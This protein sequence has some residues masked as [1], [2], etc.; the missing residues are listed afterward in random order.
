MKTYF[1]KMK[2]YMAV[3]ILTFAGAGCNSWLDL[4]PEND[5]TSDMYWNT[6]ED[7]EAVVMSGYTSMRGCLE[8]LIQWG[9]LRG[10]ALTLGTKS[11]TSEQEIYFL[12]ILTTNSVCAWK[13][14]YTVIGNANAVIKYGPTVLEK[15][16]T[17]APELM[18]SYIGEAKFMRALA[19]F[20][21]LRTFG[22]V[23]LVLEPYV[24]DA[25]E[26]KQAKVSE[27]EVLNQIIADL[28]E[29]TVKCKPGYGDIAKNKGRATSWAAYALLADVYL[30]N[31]NYQ[32]ALDACEKVI[33][34]GQFSLVKK[35][36]WYTLFNPGNTD[37]GIFELQWKSP[38]SKVTNNLYEWF[39]NSP[40]YVLSYRSTQLFSEMTENDNRGLGASYLEDKRVWKYAG[41]AISLDGSATRAAE[42]RNAN[43]IFYRYADVLLMKAEAL[44]MKER[45]VEEADRS[46]AKTWDLVKVIRERAGFSQHPGIPQNER[47]ALEMVLD[48]RHREFIGEGKRWFDIL[49]MAKRDDYQYKDYLLEVILQNVSAQDRP[50]YEAKLVD[51]RG[52]YL[53]IHKDEI[54]ANGGVLVQ[55]PYYQDLE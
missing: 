25:K 41:K 45:G 28:K 39:Y 29:A 35:A 9:E 12:Q 2:I 51:V 20:Y 7:V 43:W 55:N 37:E 49:R 52:Y 34:S 5:Q 3:L 10:D 42:D 26:F 33:G 1:K 53:P 19:Y 4:L 36:D 54:D 30:W 48:E 22:E 23:P 27:A 14:F 38:I 24:D 46:Y 31:E 32:G 15:D 44:V 50:L 47:T 17:F 8:K 21:L 13:P 40:R 16:A 18:N 6:K 11:T